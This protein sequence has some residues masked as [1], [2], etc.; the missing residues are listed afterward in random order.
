MTDKPYPELTQLGHETRL[1]AS[2]D[3]AVLES[4]PNGQPDTLYVVRFTCPEFT[5]VCPM[6]GQP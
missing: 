3:E 5:A 4:V 1:P 2:P 6:T